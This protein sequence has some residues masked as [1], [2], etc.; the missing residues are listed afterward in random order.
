MVLSIVPTAHKLPEG[1]NCICFTHSVFP[2][3]N[4]VPA[5]ENSVNPSLEID[6]ILQSLHNFSNPAFPFKKKFQAYQEGGPKEKN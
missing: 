6:G 5:R 4:K 3:P 2:K 1:R